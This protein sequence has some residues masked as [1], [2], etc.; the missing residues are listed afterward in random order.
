MNRRDLLKAALAI[1][2]LP[3]VLPRMLAPA[4]AGG[5]PFAAFPSRVRPG[6]AA[7]PSAASWEALK[8]DVGGRLLK[9]ESPFA[10][11]AVTP[12]NAACSAALRQL[13]NPYC[14][15]DQPALTQTSGWV[16]QVQAAG[17]LTGRA[18]R[19]GSP[20]AV[21]GPDPVYPVKCPG[22]AEGIGS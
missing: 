16:D 9:L 1:P 4:R 11:C 2:F 18:G 7:W 13:K 17:R 6:D 3:A 10:N 20:L 21:C 5:M 12:T 22:A 15:G 8:R 14:I 19:E